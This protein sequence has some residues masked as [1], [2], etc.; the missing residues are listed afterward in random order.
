MLQL[1]I[2]I[3]KRFRK[4][5]L[6]YCSL[7]FVISIEMTSNEFKNDILPLSDRI[8]PMATRILGNELEAQDAVQEIMIKLWVKR[9]KLDQHPNKMGFVF[10]TARNYC[11]DRL[12]LK[13]KEIVDTIS[14]ELIADYFIDEDKSE[15]ESLLILIRKIIEELPENQKEIILMRDIDGF[16][17]DEIV[18]AT[19]LKIEHI[20]VLL[21]RARKQVRNELKKTAL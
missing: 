20:R 1:A 21:S 5:S 16:E 3:K 8:F 14:R 9:N 7:F 2:L 10:L 11:L 19:N 13:K 12:R 15:L 17:F 6:L 18:A 4:S